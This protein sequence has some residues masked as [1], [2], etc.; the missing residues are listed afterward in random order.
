MNNTDNSKAR[1]QVWAIGGGKG[2]TGK[3]WVTA[4][5]GMH[6]AQTGYHVVL[7][8]GD[9]GGANLHT[10]LGLAPPPI[11]LSD[12]IKGGSTPSLEFAAVDTCV[13]RL[14]LVSGA[15]NNLQPTPRIGRLPV[16]EHP[17]QQW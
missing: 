6:L 12:I 15:R 5:L 9:L 4:S 14:R 8:D 7:V 3:S 13:P 17:E 2:G 10:F 11:S 16:P 1:P